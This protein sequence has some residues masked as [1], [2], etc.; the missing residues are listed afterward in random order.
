MTPASSILLGAVASA[1]CHY[2]VRF[3]ER[4]HIDDALDVF[5]V[6]G[7]G[8]AIGAILTGVFATSG[9][10]IHQILVQCAA[11]AV[12][13]TYT[14]A[15]TW[16]VLKIVNAVTPLRVTEDDELLGLDLSQHAEA[17]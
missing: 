6:H 5:P 14:A 4:M 8:G 9:A 15:M 1:I 7:V 12:V 2:A 13:W 16:L 3:R 11:V 10:G 17:A